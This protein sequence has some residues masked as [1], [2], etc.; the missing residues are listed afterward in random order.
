MLTCYA[1]VTNTTR[2]Y[3]TDIGRILK[4][5]CRHLIFFENHCHKCRQRLSVRRDD[6]ITE[7]CLPMAAVHIQFYQK[8]GSLGVYEKPPILVICSS[9][10][11]SSSKSTMICL[12]QQQNI[13]MQVSESLWCHQRRDEFCAATNHFPRLDPRWIATLSSGQNWALA[14][15]NSPGFYHRI[16]NSRMVAVGQQHGGRGVAGGWPS[17]IGRSLDDFGAL[18]DTPVSH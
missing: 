9:D 2:Q 6:A 18:G 8:P 5:S 11:L 14:H 3:T 1:T 12:L 15:F 4:I 16:S 13:H 10:S 7:S 17:E